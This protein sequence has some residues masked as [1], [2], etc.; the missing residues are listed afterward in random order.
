M[1]LRLLLLLTLF[2]VIGTNFLPTNSNANGCELRTCQ[3][4]YEQGC[5]SK[6]EADEVDEF[7]KSNSCGGCSSA[8]TDECYIQYGSC[9]ML[10]D[11]CG[12][13]K[14]PKLENCLNLIKNAEDI[15][16]LR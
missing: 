10:Q 1:V 4:G 7:C 13:G 3:R 11:G 12:W 15:K 8:A 6:A 2:V 14:N 9:K 16:N 5:V